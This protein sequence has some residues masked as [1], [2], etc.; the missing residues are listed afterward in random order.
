MASNLRKKL[1]PAST[2]YI[3]DINA[4]ALNRFVKEYSSYGPI[5]P[6]S[7]ARE[8]ATYSKVLV[9]IVPGAQDV[10]AV[11]LD[12]KNGVIAAGNNEE[13]ILLECSTIDV[14]STKE[15]GRRLGGMGVYIDAPVSGGV[16]A[17]EAGTLAMLIGYPPPAAS[18]VGGTES[19]ISKRL[20]NLLAMMGSPDKFF[21]LHTLGAGLTA[22]ICNNYLSGT[23]LLATAEAMATGVAHGLDPSDLYQ[24]IKNS[25]G[26]SWM[27]DHVMPV[28]NVQKEYWVPS[29]SGYK[30]GFKTQMMLKDL[31]LGIESAKQVGVEPSMAAKALEVWEKA[32]KDERCIDRDGSSIY[33]HLGGQLPEGYEDKG[34]K[35]DDGTWDFVD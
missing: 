18:S 15:V 17:A 19:Q 34:K 28:P 29:N 9:S 7:T 35:A 11:Y 27:C 20:T 13:R 24:V 33:L 1:P 6:V 4:S 16:P 26:Q 12:E 3:N 10:K 23:I 31:G 30:P 8:A 2:L 14:E 32:A 22:K 5:I 21:Y 25:T